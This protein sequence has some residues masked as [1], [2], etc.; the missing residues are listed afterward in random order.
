MHSHLSSY[1]SIDLLDM[2]RLAALLFSIL[3][4]HGFAFGQQ[5]NPEKELGTWTI[6]NGFFNL[7]PKYELFIESQLRTWQLYNNIEAWCFRP[8]FSYR[9]KPTHLVGFST[10]YFS[11]Y[12]YYE[13]KEQVN[14]FRLG[15]QDLFSY[16]LGRAVMQH[17]TRYEFRFFD[18]APNTQ[19][20]RYRIQLAVPLTKHEFKK[21]GLIWII[22]NEIF[23]GISPEVQYDQNRFYTS[24]GYNFTDNFNVQIGYQLWDR[25]DGTYNRL[26]VIFTQ[27][28]DLF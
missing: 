11:N 19:R 8:Y 14:E 22:N 23:I 10:E 1:L 2:N 20:I 15:I 4:L 6:Y 7:S 21:G 16:K 27:K 9:I 3:I 26:H 28:A 24:L 12:N 17:R 18:Q 13:P 25:R 5:K